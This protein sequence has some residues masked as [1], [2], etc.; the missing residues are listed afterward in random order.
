MIDLNHKDMSK[1][2]TDDIL[3]FISG[4]M[5]VFTIIRTV[6]DEQS[7]TEPHFVL[8]ASFGL[9]FTVSK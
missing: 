9:L 2:C 5:K 4:E 7:R 8:A 6:G 3:L 1:N